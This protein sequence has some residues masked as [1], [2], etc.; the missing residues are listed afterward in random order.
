MR[1]QA[2]QNYYS[3]NTYSNLKTNNLQT[4]PSQQKTN[5]MSTPNSQVSFTCMHNLPPVMK[6]TIKLEDKIATLAKKVVPGDMIIVGENFQKAKDVLKGSIDAFDN[7]VKR[8]FFIKENGI[9][10]PLILNKTPFDTL[11]LYNPYKKT[12]EIV[13]NGVGI[14]LPLERGCSYALIPGDSIKIG[15][16]LIKFKEGKK[17][18]ID[19]KKIH[20]YQKIDRTKDVDKEIGKLNTKTLEKLMSKSTAKKAKTITFADIGGQDSVIKE[21]KRGVLYPIKYPQAYKNAN[22]NHGILLYGPPGTGKTLIAQALANETNANFVKLNGLEM[23]SKYVGDSEKNWRKL[24][25]TAREKQPSIIFVDEFDAVA[26]T[27]DGKDVYG[28]KV[29]N[30]IL[31]LMSDI[32]KNGDDI[33]VIAA[34]NNQK[35][36]DA[37][38]TRSGRFGK[39]IEV[40]AP[41]TFDAVAQIFDIHTKNKALAKDLDKQALI[42]TL[43]AKKAT[44]ADIAH[45]VNTAHENAFERAGIYEKMEKGTFQNADI[46]NLF[47]TT[48]DF[49]KAI[50]A[51]EN[52]DTSRKPIGFNR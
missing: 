44:G 21:L 40:K 4:V 18:F 1:I 19:D 43:L 7:V 41:D 23:D 42:K 5:Y 30:Q 50:V 16:K 38:I 52:K 11:E 24:F 33:Y 27:R 9:K 15:N 29:V 22:L 28:D 46:G 3:K 39:H 2:I 10:N 25:D 17:N 45:I 12:I 31:T 47:L 49:N 48:E 51:F 35:S 36:L 37:A 8:F 6:D 20:Y 34:T 14:P 13:D 26:K 32:E